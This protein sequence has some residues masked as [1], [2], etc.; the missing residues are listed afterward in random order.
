[1]VEDRSSRRRYLK[2]T[3]AA[4]AGTS[5]AGCSGDGSS[6][7][8]S[9]GSGGSDGS[10]GSD[11]AATSGQDLEEVRMVLSPF[12][13]AGIIYDQMINATD[14]LSSRM[15]DAGYDVKAQESWEGSALFASGGP[16]LA[17][18][19]PIEAAT[20]GSERDLNLA[21]NGRLTSFFIGP[22][23]KNGG[24]YDTDTT[25]GVEASVNKIANQGKFG[26]GSWGGGDVHA[27]Q[28]V[29]P[30]RYGLAFGENQSDFEV[31]TADYFALPGLVNDGEVAAVSTAPHYGAA[32]MFAGDSP[33][34]DALFYTSDMLQ[35][36]GYG[37]SMLNS[38]VCTQEFADSNP[39][40][41]EAV[42]GAWQ[43]TV[44]DFL[45]RP[46]ELATQDAY[47]E[48]LAAEN[49]QQARWLI[50]WGVKNEYEYNT[51][52][53]YEDVTFTEDRIANER[54]FI[55]A[56]ADAGHIPSD[57]DDHLEFRTVEP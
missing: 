41:V 17:D 53:L 51:P 25:G 10:S 34:L 55:G 22:L 9:G 8:G 5:L 29:F 12:G 23:V 31:V 20:L 7:G 4:I 52:V 40:A 33:D 15:E 21:T 13:F 43:E 54:N 27:Y 28:L 6:G 42:V 46:Y 50:D 24:P 18:M 47:M 56:S 44:S 14:R 1:M 2:Y 45:S 57:W 48:M 19:S 39:G 16:D 36:M 37:A 11:G 32:P 3:G 26:I 30:E 49:E 38:W 35:E